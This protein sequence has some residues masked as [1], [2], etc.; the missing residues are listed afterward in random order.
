MFLGP[1]EDMKAWNS[2]TIVGPRRFLERV[3]K[4]T[5]K[6]SADGDEKATDA[7]L[8]K[9]IKKVGDD[10]EKF[11]FNTAI[12]SLMILVNDLEKAEKISRNTFETLL[13]LLAPFA[14]H[15]T[16]ELWHEIGNTESVHLAQWPIYDASKCVESETTVAIQV[17]GKLRDTMVVTTGTSDDEIIR[18]GLDLPNIQKWVLGKEIKKTIVVKGKLLSIVVGE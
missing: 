14:P 17:N 18:L 10:I 2:T 5:E 3:W 13:I 9:T 4:L 7:S 12:S 15:L 8:H 11:G 6:V 16:E 1:L